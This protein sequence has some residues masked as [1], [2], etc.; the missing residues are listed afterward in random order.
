[1]NTSR[2]AAK[3]S[4]VQPVSRGTSEMVARADRIT[5]YF[6]GAVALGCFGAVGYLLLR[7]W[8]RG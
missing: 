3:R 1:M 8:W 2:G 6:F 4:G 5:A 7:A